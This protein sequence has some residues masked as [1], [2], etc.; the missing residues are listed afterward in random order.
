MVHWVRMKKRDD[1]VA[2]KVNLFAD[3]IAINRFD[4]FCVIACFLFCPIFTFGDSNKN[5]QVEVIGLLPDAK[6][7]DMKMDGVE[8]RRISKDTSTRLLSPNVR[9]K[10]FE[11]AGLKSSIAR[12]DG[13]QKDL[14]SLRAQFMSLEDLKKKYPSLPHL[15]LEKLKK[16]LSATK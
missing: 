4:F 1:Q 11:E 3:N 5:P 6:V 8:V 12:W 9:D 10:S 13:Y 2:R 7:E 14:L 15:A 16:I